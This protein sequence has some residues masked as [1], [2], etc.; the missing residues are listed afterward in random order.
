MEI[1]AG[2]PPACPMRSNEE[3][4]YLRLKELSGFDMEIS[5]SKHQQQPEKPERPQSEKRQLSSTDP[6]SGREQ[7]GV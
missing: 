5:Q 1:A 7:R 3:N 4:Y 6:K 2:D